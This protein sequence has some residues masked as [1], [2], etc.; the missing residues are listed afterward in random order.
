[1]LD[2]RV[3]TIGAW[4]NYGL[5]SLSDNLPQFINIGPRFFDKRDGHYLGPAFDDAVNLKVDPNNPLDYAAPHGGMNTIQQ[6]ALI[7]ELH[8]PTQPPSGR[9]V[10]R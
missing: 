6:S 2:P 9:T 5:G 7:L 4:I 1:M 8:Q 3:P 10:S